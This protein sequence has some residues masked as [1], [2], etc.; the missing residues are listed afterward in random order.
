MNDITKW[1]IV[2]QYKSPKE[3]EHIDFYFVLTLHV[4]CGIGTHKQLKDEIESIYNEN[5]SSAITAYRES[6]L[7]NH[8][9]FHSFVATDEKMIIK[10]ASNYAMYEKEQKGREFLL[11]MIHKGYKRI[12]DYMSRINLINM[13]HL[14]SFLKERSP[15]YLPDSHM[16]TQIAIALYI[17]GQKSV[18]HKGEFTI[19]MIKELSRSVC[20]VI[21]GDSVFVDRSKNEFE[22][23]RKFQSIFNV[24]IDRTQNADAL[25][26]K[27]EHFH[28]IQLRK[29]PDVQR[30]F[31]NHLYKQSFSRYQKPLSLMMRLQGLNDTHFY[32]NTTMSREEFTDIYT[33]FQDALQKER[34]KEEEFELFTVACFLLIVLIKQYKH[35][36]HDYIDKEYEDTFAIVQENNKLKAKNDELRNADQIY[37]DRISE[38]E[39][40][41]EKQDEYIAS[42]ERKVKEQEGS[43]KEDELL[44]QE[45]L[46]LREYVFSEENEVDLTE[47]ITQD[48]K[49]DHLK[50]AVVGGHQRWHTR[51][52]QEYPQI[53]T[54]SPDE[55]TI[56]LSFL[57][58]MDIV[59]FETSY[60]NHSL[61]HKAMNVLGGSDVSIHYINGSVN[62]NTLAYQIGKVKLP[63]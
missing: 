54:V 1:T 2:G 32:A 47:D 51:I 23:L 27:I 43:V 33:S 56:D 21:N 38:L 13:D 35:L 42:L 50:V 28:G 4:I 59:C 26:E 53:R 31:H 29:R 49:I 62:P 15:E 41:L 16:F 58:N 8:P 30:D 14:T 19:E 17:G 37:R 6:P 48:I 11:R 24:K 22:A 63:T 25:I 20:H 60:S 44:R 36:R 10:V 39:A 46:A 12:E 34:V 18:N 5:L 9:F 40:K 45:V 57:N 3:I 61:Y 52:K 7:F 55:K